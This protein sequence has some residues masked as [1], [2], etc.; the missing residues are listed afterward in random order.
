M[1]SPQAAPVCFNNRAADPQYHAHARTM[2]LGGKE[3]IK[4]LV[5][6]LRWKPNA[7]IA[8]RDQHLTILA[9]LRLDGELSPPIH[10]LHGINAIHHEV[11]QNL[12]QLHAISHDLRKARSEFRPNEYCELSCLA[13]QHEPHLSNNLV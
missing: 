2:S 10:F 11:H 6:L 7:S 4:D 9:V 1:S 13:V 5:R 3:C 12:L 8:D